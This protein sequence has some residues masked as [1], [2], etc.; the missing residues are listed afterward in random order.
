MVDLGSGWTV[1]YNGPECG[2]SAPDHLHFQAV[3]S[4]HM[5]VEEEIKETKRLKNII[6]VDGILFSRVGNTG[7]EVITVEGDNPVSLAGAFGT[8]LSALKKTLSVDVEPMI[9]IIGFYSKKRLCIVIFPRAKHRPDAF[10]REGDDRL[11]VSPAVVEM[12]GI[13]VTPVKKDFEN[14]DASIA[15]DI[16]R[17]VSLD[18]RILDKVFDSIT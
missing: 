12:G 5:P 14:M 15:E 7:R 11:T 3:P 1:L 10:F 18:S 9:N 16:F 4:G 6:E 2:A 17:E 8:I 13:L